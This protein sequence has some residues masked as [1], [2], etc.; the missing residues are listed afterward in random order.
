MRKVAK[1]LKSS[2]CYNKLASCKISVLNVPETVDLSYKKKIKKS[3]G[4]QSV[5]FVTIFQVFSYLLK[6]PINLAI[7]MIAVKF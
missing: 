2:R 7:S 4:L 6:I 1:I 5:G 3:Y